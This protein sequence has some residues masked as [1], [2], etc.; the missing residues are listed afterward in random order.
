MVIETNR[1]TLRG[2]A[3]DDAGWIAREIA[4]P[5]V[6]RWLTAPPH[7]YRYEDAVGFIGLFQNDPGFC[8]IEENGAPLGMISIGTFAEGTPPELGCWLSE[9]AWGRGVMSEATAALITWFFDGGGE[10]L[11]SGWMEGNLASERILTKFGFARTGET[12]QQ[13]SRYLGREVPVV[14]VTLNKETWRAR[15]AA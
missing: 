3:L 1:L 14:R 12:Q 13:I 6:Q 11:A 8:I 4:N 9:A 2:L 5:K 15:E 7:P 10:M